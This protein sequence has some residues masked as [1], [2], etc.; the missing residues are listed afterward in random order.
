LGD[1]LVVGVGAVVDAQDYRFDAQT[2][3]LF[4]AQVVPSLD[5]RGP[6]RHGR[7]GELH[8]ARRSPRQE[9]G[10]DVGHYGQV[11]T[12]AHQR[13]WPG[14]RIRGYRVLRFIGSSSF[15]IE[16]FINSLCRDSLG[17]IQTHSTSYERVLA[18]DLSHA[19]IVGAE[20]IGLIKLVALFTEDR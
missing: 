20:G 17:F 2:L 7:S 19:S 12:G 6:V 16:K 4:F 14:A 8:V 11:L 1:C 9:G 13:E 5:D 18:Y 10:L 15:S 3:R